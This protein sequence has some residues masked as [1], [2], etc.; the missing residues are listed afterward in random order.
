MWSRCCRDLAAAAQRGRRTRQQP[1]KRVSRRVLLVSIGAV[2]GGALLLASC[3][4]MQ[5][6]ASTGAR[7]RRIGYLYGGTQEADQAR[8]DA[9]VARLHQ[10]G[11]T[12][13]DNLG[14]EWRLPTATA[15][16]CPAC[17]QNSSA[18]RWR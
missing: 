1:G 18:Y 4:L 15:S 5:P 10:L 12:E 7:V 13:G 16:A 17:Q 14:I 2:G 8:I 6:S 11:W 3:Q 9:F